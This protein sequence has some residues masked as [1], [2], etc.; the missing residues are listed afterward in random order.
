MSTR[1]LI[2]L[3]MVLVILSMALLVLRTTVAVTV[4]TNRTPAD[5]PPTTCTTDADPT[6]RWTDITLCG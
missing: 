1:Q 6:D 2:V 5:R 4:H 3:S